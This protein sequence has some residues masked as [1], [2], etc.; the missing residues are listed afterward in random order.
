MFKFSEDKMELTKDKPIKP[1]LRRMPDGWYGRINMALTEDERCET[2]KYFGARFY[3]DV[4][5]C[6]DIP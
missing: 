6:E 5:E 4:A 1:S 2:L 3:C